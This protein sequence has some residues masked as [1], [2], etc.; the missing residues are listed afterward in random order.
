M[1]HLLHLLE[2]TH[3]TLGT[4]TTASA[5]DAF[6][7]TGTH[8]ASMLI[9]V[10]VRDVHIHTYTEHMNGTAHAASRT[11]AEQPLLP[12]PS[13]CQLAQ[14]LPLLL[15]RLLLSVT[16]LLRLCCCCLGRICLGLPAGQ[17]MQ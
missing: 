12:L 15:H 10:Y 11:Y 13:V 4:C 16:Q 1:W 7:N 6:G 5:P 17:T 2:E 9:N 3:G 14:A 8:P